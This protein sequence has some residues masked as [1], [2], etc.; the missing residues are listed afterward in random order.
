ME[1]L[2]EEEELE[3]LEKL[4]EEELEAVELELYQKRT[5]GSPGCQL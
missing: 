5:K 4:E 1:S 3:E 2:R